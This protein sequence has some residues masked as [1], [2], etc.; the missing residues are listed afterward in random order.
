M[1]MKKNGF[2]AKNRLG[3]MV[4]I[5]AGNF[6]MGS[7][8]DDSYAG[9]DEFPQHSVYLPEYRI[10]KYQVTRGEYRKF[11]EAGGYEEPKYWSAEGW[12][13]KESDDVYHAGMYGHLTSCKRENLL[14]PRREP[15]HWASEQEWIGHGHD[16]PVFI[17]TD[18]H[19]VVGVACHEAEAYCA[20]AGARLPT[21]A[22]YEKA[23]RWDEANKHART[24]PWGDVWDAE[25]CKNKDARGPI[26][27]GYRTNRSTPVG[28]YLEGASPCGCLDMVGNAY[29]W[30][31]DWA[32]SH[33]GNA[34]L[35]DFTGK[36]RFVKGG[37]WDD[38]Q[39]S[40][41][42]AFRGWYLPMNSGGTD[43]TDCDYVGFRLAL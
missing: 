40:N 5:P 33:P 20:W 37:C 18:S 25:K 41:R 1:D 31:G 35:F 6:M 2:D 28:S 12:A 36:Y 4:V 7:S 34:E 17:Q 42:C 19:P 13:W 11:I 26:G 15:E 24:W 29:E 27:G 21:E 32:K 14:S 16:H 39:H 8:P 30:C 38:D 3:E 22:E 43:A 9:K 23:A 10:G